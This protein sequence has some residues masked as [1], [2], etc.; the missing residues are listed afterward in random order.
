MISEG[1]LEGKLSLLSHGYF[2]SNYGINII[3]YKSY[4]ASKRGICRVIS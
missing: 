2:H 4:C 1:N 3:I